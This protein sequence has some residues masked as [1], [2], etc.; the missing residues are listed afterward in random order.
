AGG[1]FGGGLVN[2]TSNIPATVGI[3]GDTLGF[4]S[5]RSTNMLPMVTSV[6]VLEKNYQTPS[7]GPSNAA[8]TLSGLT[9]V[10]GRKPLLEIRD[11]APVLGGLP[12]VG[13]L[14]RSETG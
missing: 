12:V 14:F 7:A 11:N 1:G 3:N 6:V 9:S 5:L 8:F 13:R 4:P 2:A 10:A